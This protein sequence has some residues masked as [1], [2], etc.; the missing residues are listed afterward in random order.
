MDDSQ[1]WKN[2]GIVILCL[3]AIALALIVVANA[4]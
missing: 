2:L 4:I 3:C 1:V